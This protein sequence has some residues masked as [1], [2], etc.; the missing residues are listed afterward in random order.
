MTRRD[1]RE[2]SP[3]RSEEGV[4]TAPTLSAAA[5]IAELRGEIRRLNEQLAELRADGDV[6]TGEYPREITYMDQP[7]S[8]ARLTG[9]TK[10]RERIRPSPDF[11]ELPSP[12]RDRARLEADFV[13]WGYCL[14]AGA[15]S[16]EQIR[17]QVD[18]LLDQAE[19]ER[20]AKVAH[21]SHR[22]TAQLVFN[23]LAKG[24]VFR[25]LVSLEPSV[26]Q[27]A[28]L[29]EDLLGKILGSSYYL[30]TAH[31]SIVHQHGGRQELHQ[32][33]GFVPLPH[34]P[35]PL[36][37]LVIWTY[38]RFSLED[39]GTYVVPGSHRDAAGRN[40]VRPEAAFEKMAEERIVALTAPAGCCLLTDSR[41]LHSGGKR[42][43][44]G[45]RLAS[46]ILYARGM[47]RQ[48]ENQLA[49][50]PREIIDAASP[51]LK[52]L[53]GFKPHYGLGMVDGN[54]IDPA[55]PRVH[56]GELSMS[57]PEEFDQDFDWNYTE[58]ARQ[59]SLRP[60]ESHAEYRGPVRDTHDSQASTGTSAVD[61]IQTSKP[62]ERE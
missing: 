51:K 48:Q 9:I 2:I 7:M 50:V 5:E 56:V 29:V 34:P 35:Y 33:Q 32:D 11:P 27:E 3:G 37:C 44:S 24:Q 55:R 46:R 30:G 18:R 8:G 23:L 21:L 20:A 16:P 43:A 12:T 25:D 40:K 54:T 14:V 10:Q 31:G 52:G 53:V 61:S 45:T 59:L 13:R 19:A 17:A 38:T 6:E 58:N 28:E 22:G 60:W 1:E 39:G 47:M 15:M 4:N 42:T 26:V 49:S 41:L 57:R 36:Y 62:D